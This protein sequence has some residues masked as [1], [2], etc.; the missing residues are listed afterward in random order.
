MPGD[1]FQGECLSLAPMGSK[2][3]GLTTSPCDCPVSP[4]SPA[5]WRAYL[6]LCFYYNNLFLLLILHQSL[7]C[8]SELLQA[9]FTDTLSARVSQL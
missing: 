1:S 4:Q 6:S 8:L 5:A 9:T 3:A 2:D 7:A